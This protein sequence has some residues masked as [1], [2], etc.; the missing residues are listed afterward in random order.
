M[1]KVPI[2]NVEDIFQALTNR[3]T[4][5]NVPD[6][7]LDQEYQKHTDDIVNFFMSIKN[8]IRKED[9]FN[10]Q[11]S[12]VCSSDDNHRRQQHYAKCSICQGF[13]NIHCIS[14]NNVWLCVDHWKQHRGD[15]HNS[16]R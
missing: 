13:A 7:G 12:D 4:L 15:K 6:Q 14:C 11:D 1:S 3:Q 16:K 10:A 5:D 2:R 8:S 9:L